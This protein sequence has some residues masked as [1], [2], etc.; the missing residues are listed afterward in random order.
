LAGVSLVAADD[1]YTASDAGEP[2]LGVEQHVAAFDQAQQAFQAHGVQN[3]YLGSREREAEPVVSTVPPAGQRDEHLPLRGHGELLSELANPRK[4]RVRVVHGLGGCG[5]TRLALEVAFQA[6]QRGTE[7]WWVSAAEPA[8]LAAGMR[9]LGRRLGITDAQLQ[10]GDA[11]D[12]I[13][14]QLAG[15]QQ[16]WLLVIDNADDALLLAGAGTCVA[17]GRG[18]LRPLDGQ[19]GMVL[20]TSRDG[21]AASWGPW[22]RRHQLQVLPN[23]LAAAVL[24]DNAGHHPVLGSEDEAQRLAARLG[25]LP[26]ALKI[27]G[28]YLA[29]AAA[30][31]AAF[32]D[33]TTIGT[34]QQYLEAIEGGDLAAV[35]LPP[36]GQ[37]SAKQARGLIG[38]TWELTLDLLDARPLP[39]ARQVLRLLACFADAPIPYQLLLHPATLAA[40]PLLRD[41]A[42][43]RLWQAL[44]ALDD[45]G[46]IDLGTSS[47]T[48]VVPVARI[49]PLVHD[50]SRPSAEQGRMAF[51]GL[52]AQLLK[53]AA[54]AEEAGLPETL[55][56]WPIWHLLAPHCAAVFAS[57]IAEP[58]E[59]DDT[60]IG[61]AFAAYM[62][63][64]Y[65]ASQGFNATAEAGYRDVLAARLRVLGPDHPDTLATQHC[66]ALVMAAQ[67]DHTAAEAE[68][69]DVLAVKLRVL[70]PDHQATLNTRHCIAMEMAGRGD[71]TAAEAEYRDVLAARQRVLGPDHP[72]TLATRHNIALE[73]AGR[74]DHTAAEA[75]YR[76][77]LAARQRV[78]G[79]DH[80]ATLNTRHSI[81]AQI[82]ARGDHAEA[83]AE[84]RKV[85]AVNLRVLG[86]HHPYTLNTRHSIAAQL[87]AQGDHAAARTELQNILDTRSRVLGPDH[88]DT[89]IIVKWIKSLAAR[90]T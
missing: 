20:V 77:V 43:S 34:Y 1:N 56:Q 4:A 84:F 89:Q 40:F 41:I 45:F 76:D 54:T 2:K 75:E 79:P 55:S 67:G 73:M 36:G 81:A 63:A 29:E 17:E 80:Q 21:S 47:Q 50:T 86:P 32:I 6:Q 30:I 74:G 51:V 26:L 39:E 82:A 66:I 8:L 70:G 3:V 52:A 65:Q 58:T 64:R 35:F 83:E 44:R 5:K 53:R 16:P 85:L 22:T 72:D 59:S 88:P 38:R 57:V 25:G 33:I 42:G 23:D 46:L 9:S 71:H 24:A 28:S 62:A 48:L 19:A 69:R 13:W 18:W 10:H 12:V 11:A 60:V 61:A 7:V 78:L 31:P 87:A 27:A 90:N 15:R 14:Q 37:L 49:H 68:F